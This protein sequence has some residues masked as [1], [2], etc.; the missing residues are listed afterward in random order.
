MAFL[1]KEKKFKIIFPQTDC[2]LGPGQYIS[3]TPKRL[4]KQNKA[5]FGSSMKKMITV[6]QNYPGPGAYYQ[7]ESKQKINELLTKNNFFKKISKERKKSMNLDSIQFNST[8]LSQDKTINEKVKKLKSNVEVAG[9]S[10]QEKR[11]KDDLSKNNLIGPGYYFT[12]TKSKT[13]KKK[14]KIATLK[15]ENYKIRSTRNPTGKSSEKTTTVSTIPS[16]DKQYGYEIT[17][18]GYIKPRDNPDMSKTYSGDKWDMVGPGNYNLNLPEDWHRTGTEWSKYRAYRIEPKKDKS[19]ELKEK[20]LNSITNSKEKNDNP[21]DNFDK[22]KIRQ[23]SLIH[24]YNITSEPLPL[25]IK[26]KGFISQKW[27]ETKE[28]PGPGYYYEEKYWSAFNYQK[29]PKRYKSDFDPKENRFH[30]F[31]KN[32]NQISP[33]S[34]F[35]DDFKKIKKLKQKYSIEFLNTN[36]SYTSVKEIPFNSTSERFKPLKKRKSLTLQMSPN[37]TRKNKDID[38]NWV[39]KTFNGKLDKFGSFCPRFENKPFNLSSIVPLNVD[40]PSPGTYIN[41][42]TCTGESNTVEFKGKLISIQKAKQYSLKPAE[43]SKSKIPHLEN[44]PVGLYN[45]DTV[46]SINYIVQKRISK[47]NRTPFDSSSPKNTFL[48]KKDEVGPG[49]Y[50]KEDSIEKIQIKP[51]FHTQSQKIDNVNNNSSVGPGQYELVPAENWRKKE[52]NIL[53]L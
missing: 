5:P 6:K 15:F 48:V 11:F 22:N 28:Y 20:I 3:P 27:K 39:R 19:R 29:S 25:Y 21:N 31:E 2:Q 7:E 30:Y 33:A 9:F 10:V 36:K 14:S 34:Y 44:P 43:Q 51:P 53:Y 38:K 8:L 42:Y 40:F 12:D 26:N 4:I 35:Q 18:D 24:K 41:P 37:K 49:S 45:P 1:T 17:D 13:E 16:K 32:A 23:K 47:A 50:Y 52:F 46:Q